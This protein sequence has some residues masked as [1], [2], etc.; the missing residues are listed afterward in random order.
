MVTSERFFFGRRKLIH[1][2]YKGFFGTEEQD[3]QVQDEG[4][5]D[6]P[7]MGPKEATARFYFE[8]TFQLAKED[9]TKMR[10]VEKQGLY[11]SLSVASILKDRIVKQQE[12]LRKIKSQNDNM[13]N[14]IR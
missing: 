4:D 14:N 6:T 13:L 9:I 8:L 3:E 5:E 11:L 7:Q 12:E 2:Q 1:H 10:D